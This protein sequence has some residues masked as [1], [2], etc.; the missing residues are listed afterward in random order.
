MGLPSPLA[1]FEQAHVYYPVRYPDGDWHPEGLNF[2]DAWF[3]ASDGTRL[4][5]WFVPHDRPRAVALFAH[6]NAGN[7]SHRAA[8]LRLLHDR[9]ELAVLAFDYR[10]YG[11]S[12]GT[13]SEWGLLQDARAARA[14]L[15]QRTGLDETDLLLTGRSLGG[16]VMVELA[17]RDGARG[18]VLASTFTSLPDVARQHMPLIPA[19]LLMRNRFDSI[20]KLGD[21]RGPLLQS[22][23]DADRVVGY[24]LGVRLHEAANGPKRFITIPGGGHNDPQNEDYRRAFDEFIDALP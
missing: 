8:S 13:P 21:Y 6:G 15:S 10:G 18:L 24:A 7:V 2:E 16:A 3:T 4:H 9:H 12:E 23:G 11:R 1:S 19:R 22:H 14:W 5:G 17:A 20:S